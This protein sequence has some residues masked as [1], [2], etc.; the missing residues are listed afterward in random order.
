MIIR[1]IIIFIVSAGV[2]EAF[3]TISIFGFMFALE[4]DNTKNSRKKKKTKKKKKTISNL[5]GL[6]MMTPRRITVIIIILHKKRVIPE[7]CETKNTVKK[8]ARCIGR[9]GCRVK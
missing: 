4:A 2:S 8:V 5:A 6:A 9:T 1:I 3:V 7:K